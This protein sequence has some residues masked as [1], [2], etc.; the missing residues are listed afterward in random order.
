VIESYVV[1][2]LA[3]SS[4]DTGPYATEMREHLG[5][6]I[7]LL[8]A[9]FS[10]PERFARSVD[11]AAK[12]AVLSQYVDSERVPWSDPSLQ[13]LDLEYHRIDKG[14]GLFQVL[15]ELGAVDPDPTEDDVLDRAINVR[16]ATR[17]RARSI[18]VTRFRDQLATA[19]WGTL[20]FNTRLGEKC[21]QLPPE[22]TYPVTLERCATVEDFIMELERT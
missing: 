20:T 14:E 3:C 21:V 13:S 16:E 2:F 15:L 1:P 5:T 8:E 7:A 19:S 18:A 12:R 22:K 17:A 6:A 4:G 11:W 9:R 10:D